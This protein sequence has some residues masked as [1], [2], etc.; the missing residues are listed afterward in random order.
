MEFGESARTPALLAEAGVEYLFDWPNDEQPYPLTVP[1]G[2][3]LSLPVMIELDDLYT[4]RM[5]RLP[6]HRLSTL[7]IEAF[8]R[9]YADGEH[10]G[11]LLVLSVHPWITGQPFHI[12][13]FLDALA[14]IVQH[15]AVWS[16]RAGDIADWYWKRPAA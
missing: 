15:P 16:A 9:L 13:G 7:M 8:D 1:K 10:A 12:R 14:H 6:P 2:R 5:R 11:R 3:M 4:R